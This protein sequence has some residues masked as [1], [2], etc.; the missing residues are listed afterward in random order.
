[1]LRDRDPMVLRTRIAGRGVAQWAQV[2]VAADNRQTAEKL[3][4]QLRA[5]GGAC[6]VLKT[7]RA[8]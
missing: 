8:R 7:P 4:S 6:M 3:C 2:R 5:A 1:V